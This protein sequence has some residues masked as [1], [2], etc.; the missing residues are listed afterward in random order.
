MK[1]FVV[2]VLVLLATGAA[3]AAE[4]RLPP[5][6]WWDNPALVERV[7]LTGEQQGK[8]SELVYKHA[9]TMIDLKAA[10]ERR[11]LELSN[12]VDQSAF[13]AA[14]VRAAFTALQSARQSLETAHF[15]LLLSIRE[16][17]SLEQW[18]ALQEM[19][20]EVV[21]RRAERERQFGEEPAP[22]RPGL[23]RQERPGP[24]R[25]P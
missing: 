20:E 16:L 24:Q 15:E 5:G 11:E 21:R 7:K 8:I 23:G 2:V 12:L 9:L 1:R 3:G 22:G 14:K 13:D 6:K 4:L 25:R 17:L 10:V 18:Q 19:H